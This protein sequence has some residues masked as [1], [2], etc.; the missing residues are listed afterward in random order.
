MTTPTRVRHSRAWPEPRHSVLARAV[1]LVGDGSVT[2]HGV[3]GV[4][5]RIPPFVIATKRVCQPHTGSTT[6]RCPPLGAASSDPEDSATD[7]PVV[8]HKCQIV[9]YRASAAGCR[10][11]C[12]EPAHIARTGRPL[13]AWTASTERRDARSADLARCTVAVQ[14]VC[15]ARS[16]AQYAA[17]LD[18]PLADC[19][20]RCPI[21]LSRSRPYMTLS[22]HALPPGQPAL[23]N[24]S[25]KAAGS[26][27]ELLSVI[28]QLDTGLQ[29]V[30]RWW[31]P[32]NR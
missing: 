26:S 32:S 9:P 25:P 1:D 11:C 28:V 23:D 20:S 13:P 17:W 12:S 6:P 7:V 2:G 14:H 5:M 4:G 15:G 16:S 3:Q 30:G 8:A 18:N 27:R 31:V 10:A 19:H 29:A 24:F 21:S 22:R